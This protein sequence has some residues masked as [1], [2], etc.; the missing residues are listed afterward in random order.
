MSTDRKSDERERSVERSGAERREDVIKSLSAERQIGRS[1]S[2]HMLCLA[3]IG[4][5]LTA[6]LVSVFFVF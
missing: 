4:A 1:R 2:V 6:L 3:E 5:L